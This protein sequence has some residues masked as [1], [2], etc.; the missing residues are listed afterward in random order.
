MVPIFEYLCLPRV[1]LKGKGGQ[2]RRAS[3]RGTRLEVLSE[4]DFGEVRKEGFE[5]LTSLLFFGKQFHF[6]W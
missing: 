5:G 2:C 4:I 3:V 6:Y 1:E